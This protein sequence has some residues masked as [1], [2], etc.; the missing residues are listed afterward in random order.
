MSPAPGTQISKFSLVDFGNIRGR[1]LG[2]FL[3]TDNGTEYFNF[4]NSGDTIWQVGV[5]NDSGIPTSFWRDHADAET[6]AFYGVLNERTR[7]YMAAFGQ[8]GN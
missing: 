1:R 8:A 5:S 3:E 7:L 2:L 6:R 4:Y